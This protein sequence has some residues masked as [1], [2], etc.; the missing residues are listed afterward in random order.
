MVKNDE[1]VDWGEVSNL[2]LGIGNNEITLFQTKTLPIET[3][4][5]NG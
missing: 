1:L 4:L 5:E 3:A 2:F